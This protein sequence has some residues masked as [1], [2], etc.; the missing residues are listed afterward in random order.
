MAQ[1][2][3]FWSE[4]WQVHK[5]VVDELV[6]EFGYLMGLI[7]D[8]MTRKVHPGRIF[9]SVMSKSEERLEAEKQLLEGEENFFQEE[10]RRGGSMDSIGA[11]NAN[12]KVALRQRHNARPICS[13]CPFF[14]GVFSFPPPQ[15]IRFCVNSCESWGSHVVSSDSFWA[16]SLR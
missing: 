5:W 2:K 15:E 8:L 14:I 10:K 3:L 16:C 4:T 9:S 7:W 1:G 12:L 13:V 11:P 6:T